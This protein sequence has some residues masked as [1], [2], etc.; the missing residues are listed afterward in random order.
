[1][2]WPLWRLAANGDGPVG[3]AEAHGLL[4]QLW[5]DVVDHLRSAI[6]A[7]LSLPEALIQ[8]GRQGPGR[9]S[10]RFCRLRLRLPVGRQFDPSFT[11]LKDRLADPVADRIVEALRLTREV[12][13]SDLAAAVGHPRRASCGRVPGPGVNWRA[14]QAGPSTPPAWQSLRPRLSWCCCASRPGGCDGYNTPVGAAVLLGGLAVSLV[15]YAVMLRIGALPEDQRVCR[16]TGMMA[17]AT[18]CGA[19]LG[20]GLGCSSSGFPSC[21]DEFVERIGRN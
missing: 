21:A 4:R 8:L 19:V 3:V 20:A 2:L 14:R 1:M 6:R 9:A 12:G 13:G 5:P 17:A 10:S 15:S 7:G 11:R 18:L 16:R